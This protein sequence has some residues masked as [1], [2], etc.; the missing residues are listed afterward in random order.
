LNNDAQGNPSFEV[1]L[2]V[3]TDYLT[4]QDLCH[5]GSDPDAGLTITPPKLTEWTAYTPILVTSSGTVTASSSGFWRRVGDT[6]EINIFTRVSACTGD[7]QFQWSPPSG[8]ALDPAKLPFRNAHVGTAQ[9]GSPGGNIIQVGLA[10]ADTLTTSSV[11]LDGPGVTCSGLLG[12]T[13][14]MRLSFAL[15]VKGWTVTGP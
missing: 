7:G 11:A 8:I 3:N 9:V 4:F 2:H 12:G 13:G 5:S 6:I 15:P 1:A 10:S 14:D